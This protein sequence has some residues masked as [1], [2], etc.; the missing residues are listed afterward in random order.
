MS[1]KKDAR[2]VWVKTFVLSFFE[3]GLKKGFT[4][5]IWDKCIILCIW[6]EH[7]K[8]SKI[9]LFLFANK[10]LVI[11]NRIHKNARQNSKQARPRSGCS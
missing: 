7:S 3:W 8:C 11:R 6:D 9:F 2:L 5:F 4:V 10:M 1:Y